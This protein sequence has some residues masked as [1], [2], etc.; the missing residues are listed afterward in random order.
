MKYLNANIALP[1]FLVEELQNYVQG[2]YLYIPIKK[3]QHRKWGELSGC[4]KEI[5]SRNQ[6]IIDKYSNGTSIEE[7]SDTYYLSI[8]AIRKI[9]YKK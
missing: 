6:E 5:E 3:G 1:D 7:L 8:Y 2:E 4:R 9:I